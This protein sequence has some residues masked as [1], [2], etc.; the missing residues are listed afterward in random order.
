M[1][2]HLLSDKK[3]KNQPLLP[4]RPHFLWF[5][6]P[7][8]HTPQFLFSVMHCDNKALQCSVTL[9][10][11]RTSVQALKEVVFHKCQ[12]SQNPTLNTKT[13][14]FPHHSKIHE[15]QALPL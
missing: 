13:N 7:P 12:G 4:E 1:L 14:S 5:S 2:L 10:W 11:Y 8:P 15:L 9:P 6:S 3:E